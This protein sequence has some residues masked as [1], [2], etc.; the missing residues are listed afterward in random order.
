MTRPAPEFDYQAFAP[1]LIAASLVEPES[2]VDEVV[3]MWENDDWS[4]AIWGALWNKAW[5]VNQ[6]V[7]TRPTYGTGTN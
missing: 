7:S 4:D 5:S 3:D 1:R 2:S 6:E